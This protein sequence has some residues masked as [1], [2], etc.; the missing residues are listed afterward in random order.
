ME[1]VSFLKSGTRLGLEVI[2]VQYILSVESIC[3]CRSQITLDQCEEC[4][5]LIVLLR[6]SDLTRLV[7]GGSLPKCALR[8]LLDSLR[9]ICLDMSLLALMVVWILHLTPSRTSCLYFLWFCCPLFP[10]NNSMVFES[11]SSLYTSTFGAVSGRSALMSVS[12][13]YVL[14]TS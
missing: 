4:R 1:L 5:I 7:F 6:L 12:W 3:M 8:Q 11:L 10:W 13:W 2:F 14:G 9:Y